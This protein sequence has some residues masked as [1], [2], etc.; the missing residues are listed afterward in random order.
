MIVRIADACAPPFPITLP[1]SSFATRSSSTWA[2]SPI[3]SLI[4]TS[5]GRSTSDCTIAMMSGFICPSTSAAP[6]VLQASPGAPAFYPR[7]WTPSLPL[8]FPETFASAAQYPRW[9]RAGK[10][11]LAQASALRSR[12]AT[13][14][15]S[16]RTPRGALDFV[17]EH[18]GVEADLEGGPVLREIV[19]V[20]GAAVGPV[21]V[22][23][24]ELGRAR[25]LVAHARVA[26]SEQVG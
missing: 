19:R 17:L 9:L 21:P 1:R 8:T 11:P 6:T 16:A 26:P 15:C 4:W 25:D 13:G 23:Q 3:T 24:D 14:K 5:S 22:A 20:E 12:D 18:G 2:C 10:A 7:S